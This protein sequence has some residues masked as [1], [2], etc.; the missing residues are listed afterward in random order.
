MCNYVIMGLKF[1]Q[2]HSDIV[3]IGN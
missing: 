1:N 2:P 3:L